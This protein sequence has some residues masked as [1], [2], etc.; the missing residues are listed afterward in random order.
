MRFLLFTVLGALALASAQKTCYDKEGVASSALM[1]CGPQTGGD[2]ACCRPV[3]DVCLSNGLCYSPG[4]NTLSFRGCTDQSG[5][6]SACFQECKTTQPA[7]A[8]PL[9]PCG[10]A[11][12]FCCGEDSIARNCCDTNNNT[13]QIN[14]PGNTV[15]NE[16]F[17]PPA[18]ANI[19]A[20]ATVT[21]TAVGST[22]TSMNGTSDTNNCLAPSS[23]LGLGLGVGLGVGI[24]VVILVGILS[25]FFGKRMSGTPRNDHNPMGDRVPARY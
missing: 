25:F 23:K 3:N 7:G 9:T 20:N 15:Y 4:L 22:A 13:F 12:V 8:V 6:S 14:S 18:S 24:P 21:V 19:S 1:P 16:Y 17:L 10:T 11:M 2:S 5:N